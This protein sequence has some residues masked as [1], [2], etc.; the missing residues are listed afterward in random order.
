VTYGWANPQFY[1]GLDHVEPILPDTNYSF[2]L[3]MMPRD[4]TVLPGSKIKLKLEG[5]NGNTH[6][7]LDL[8]HTSVNM[9]MVPKARVVE[10][11][12]TN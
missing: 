3:E 12:K 9:P 6:V 5:F 11:M 2:A 7:T 1:N 8:A 4:F 10:V